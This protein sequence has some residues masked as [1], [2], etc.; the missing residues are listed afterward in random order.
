MKKVL[1]VMTLFLMLCGC[2]QKEESDEELRAKIGMMFIIRPDALDLSIPLDEVKD[3]KAEGVKELSDAMKQ[4]YAKYPCGGFAIFKKNMENPEQL[5]KLNEDLHTLNE[6][7]LLCVDEEGGLVARIANHE[8][9][10]VEQFDNMQDIALTNDSNNAYILGKT[11]GEYLNEYGFD[12]DFAPVADV[13]TNPDNTVIGV[14]AFGDDPKVA[15]EMVSKV[16]EGLHESGIKSTIKHFPGHGDTGTDSHLGY[17]ETLKTWDEINELEMITFKKGIEANTDLVM[18]AHIAA[19]NVTGNGE[20]TT[21]SYTLLTEKLRNELGFKGVIITDAMEM[22]AITKE[23]DSA[24]AA[25]KAIQ[26][27]VDIIL[28]PEDYTKAFDGVLEAVKNGEISI[29]R[30]NE[31]VERIKALSSAN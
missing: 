11:I 1:L 6:N 12:I 3:S 17:S 20:P 18:A 23:Y 27:G 22:G 9:F 7:I 10:D 8:A 13:N 25:I 5:I 15:A 16:I 26:A 19:P 29:E 31:S 30:I 14:R 2:G 21:L 28:M 4:T 24:S